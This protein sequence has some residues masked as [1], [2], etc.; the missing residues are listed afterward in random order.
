MSKVSW[1][2]TKKRKQAIRELAKEK[3]HREGEL[4]IDDYSMVSEGDDNGAYVQA[5]VWVSF[6]GTK[7]DKE[8]KR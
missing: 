8:K 4:E 3:H 2:E 6:D 7:L 5:W 1:K